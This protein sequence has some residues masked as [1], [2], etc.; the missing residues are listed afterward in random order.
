MRGV[1]CWW[2]EGVVD[3][4]R[5][6]EEVDID[7]I[8]AVVLLFCILYFLFYFGLVFFTVRETKIICIRYSKRNSG[9][10]K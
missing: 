1:S 5:G 10:K 9:A 2:G 7:G 6:R 8:V 3:S 4:S